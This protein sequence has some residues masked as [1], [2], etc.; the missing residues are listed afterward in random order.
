V[1]GADKGNEET[2]KVTVSPSQLLKILQVYGRQRREGQR[3][4]KEQVGKQDESGIQVRV[5]AEARRRQ[6]V[7]RVSMEI[8]SRLADNNYPPGGAEAEILGQLSQA[9]GEPLSLAR[10]PGSGRLRFYV[11]NSEQ[12]EIVRALG[13]ED[14][15]RLAEALH[16]LA[17]H[18]VDQT[19]L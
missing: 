14:S 6:V 18:F 4:E 13:V 5:S 11:V 17:S 9:F 1:K 2:W 10:E 16:E 12:G 3:L 15:G 7:E 8:V 19:M